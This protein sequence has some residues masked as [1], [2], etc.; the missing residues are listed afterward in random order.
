M[1]DAFI[2]LAQAELRQRIPN[3]LI[4][5]KQEEVLRALAGGKH[6][7]A[8]LPTGYG[9]SLCY[10]L[11]AAAWGWRVWVLCPLI[12][13]MEDQLNSC[14]ELGLNAL[15]LHS[16]QSAAERTAASIRLGSGD[17]QILFL[18]PERLAMWE[19]SGKF[20][21]FE[22][23]GILPGL[24]ALDEM[25]CFEDWRKF[26]PSYAASFGPLR[27]LGRRG[28]RLLG[29]SASFTKENSDL[30]MREFCEGYVRVE[31]GLGRE[32]ISLL[33]APLEEEWERWALLTA[34]LKDLR[35]PDSALIYC[36]SQRECDDLDLWLRS[37]GFPSAAYH[38]GLPASERQARTRAFRAGRLRIVCATSAFGMGIDYPY[39]RRVI[40]FSLPYDLE[41]YWQE[42]GRAGRDGLPAFG[43]ALWR[44]SEISRMRRME[45]SSRKKYYELW[46]SWIEGRCRLQSLAQQFGYEEK[47]CGRCDRCLTEGNRKLPSVL[48]DWSSRVSRKVWWLE[49]EAS[50]LTWLEKKYFSFPKALDRPSNPDSV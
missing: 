27:R 49:S 43:L 5:P 3:S 15:A 50:P 8:G 2:A 40:H 19:E 34:S 41:S 48:G 24:V 20:S 46:R 1:H 12:S 22:D 10:W 11:P 33:V 26:R 16:G 37:A 14:R 35:E 29:L 9:K 21:E 17:W 28:C 6:V 38:A 31:A 45:E 32:N 13:L 18:S 23:A 7:F 42:V 39:V 25:H 30:W 4:K 47:N 36:S 44:R